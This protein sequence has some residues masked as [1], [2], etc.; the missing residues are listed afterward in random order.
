[1]VTHIAFT[2]KKSEVQQWLGRP[3]HP[4]LKNV[5]AESCSLDH[6][7]LV[8][9]LPAPQ[10]IGSAE[11]LTDSSCESRILD[12]QSE[13]WWA[14]YVERAD[15]QTRIH[16]EYAKNAAKLCEGLSLEQKT[17]E[18]AEQVLRH[19][20][21]QRNDRIIP[22]SNGSYKFLPVHLSHAFGNGEGGWHRLSGR[23]NK[24]GFVGIIIVQ[25]M[26]HRSIS[27]GSH[28]AWHFMPETHYVITTENVRQCFM[29]YLERKE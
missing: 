16:Q 19:S 2:I 7:T 3:P 1:V 29:K 12:I 5:S 24:G 20:S 8:I 28:P 9:K 17:K 25:G 18:R 26:G 10:V 22:Q 4:N 14:G 27:K 15:V 13:G 6:Q 23:V 11:V 21:N